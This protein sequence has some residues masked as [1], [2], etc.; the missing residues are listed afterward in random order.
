[1]KN[2]KG[3]GLYGL[4]AII[5]IAAVAGVAIWRV[6]ASKK[7]DKPAAT[8]AAQEAQQPAASKPAA[9]APVYPI[10]DWQSHTDPTFKYTVKFPKEWVRQTV[11]LE[12][13]TPGLTMLA[14]TA[15]GLGMCPKDS[16]GPVMVVAAKQSAD[17]GY[18]LNK[19]DYPD[20]AV[21]DVTASGV[22]GKK[23]VGTV[24]PSENG[25]IGPEVGSVIIHYVY[26]KDGTEY[27]VLYTEA[28][29]GTNLRTI[30]E[31]LAT[32]GLTF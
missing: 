30:V 18:I 9:E 16:G 28:P 6:T 11:N 19:T 4:L 13:C 27:A 22:A 14:P 1:M 15:E 7:D 29:G 21:S 32:K 2:T 20:L 25:G 3:F 31:L 17:N 12:Y 23:Y 24:Q 8:T 10:A 26:V 5:V